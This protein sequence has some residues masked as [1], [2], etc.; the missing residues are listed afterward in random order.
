[1]KFLPPIIFQKVDTLVKVVY[2]IEYIIAYTNNH[3]ESEYPIHV[4]KEKVN[5]SSLS[6]NP[7]SAIASQALVSAITHVVNSPTVSAERDSPS[8]LDST[9]SEN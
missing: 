7:K 8:I 1:M 2:N 6:S 5:T 9:V 4:L 3:I